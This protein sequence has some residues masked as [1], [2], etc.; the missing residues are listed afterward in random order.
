ME[1]IL[2][3]LDALRKKFPEPE[4]QSSLNEWE[5]SAKAAFITTNL[6]NNDAIKIIIAQYRKELLDLN[7]ILVTDSALFKDEAGRQLGSLIHERKNWCANFLKI[8]SSSQALVDGME[9]H[10]DNKLNDED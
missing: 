7:K 3:K 6:Q 2:E 10:L 4:D 5:R 8:F 1:K 9:K